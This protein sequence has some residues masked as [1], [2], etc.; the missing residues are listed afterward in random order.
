[1]KTFIKDAELTECR[2]LRQSKICIL[3]YELI[4]TRFA[5]F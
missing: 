4:L 5:N 2:D 1:M 3:V